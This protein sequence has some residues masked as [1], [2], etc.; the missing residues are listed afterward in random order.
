MMLT[1]READ[2]LRCITQ[3]VTQSGVPPSFQEMAQH[4]NLKSKSGVFRI[5]R[6]LEERGFIRRM[7]H[8]ARAIQ[9]LRSPYGIPGGVADER[10]R[11]A[12]IVETI[13]HLDSRLVATMIRAGTSAEEVADHLKRS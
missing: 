11:C 13:G 8:R 7:A 2:L 6:A 9:I 10:E 5:L 1:H 4:M 3:R 12:R